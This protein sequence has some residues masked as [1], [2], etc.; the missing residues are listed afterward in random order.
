MRISF[1]DS[2]NKTTT[3]VFIDDMY[4]GSVE[5]NMWTAKWTMKPAF[6]LPYNFTDVKKEIFD[7]AYHAGKKMVNLY[8][9]LLPLPDYDEYDN[10]WDLN[11]II[12]SL[13]Y[14]RD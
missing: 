14:L 10:Y 13:K 12:S 7:S 6:N 4:I 8:N 9:F 3:E 5:M 1:K 11:D 2:K